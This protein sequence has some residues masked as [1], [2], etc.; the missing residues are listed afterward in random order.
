MRSGVHQG[1]GRNLDGLEVGMASFAAELILEY[2]SSSIL[3]LSVKFS[4][5]FSQIVLFL[6]NIQSAF[7][8]MRTG[9][10]LG[11][12]MWVEMTIG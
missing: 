12:S 7:L 2:K 5:M 3:I 9:S 4:G 8:I 11:S 6:Y 10:G 1:F